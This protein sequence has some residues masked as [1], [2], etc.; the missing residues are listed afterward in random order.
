MISNCFGTLESTGST[1]GNVVTTSESS[2]TQNYGS[3][4]H[5]V[6]LKRVS[7]KKIIYD[8]FKEN[9]K[10]VFRNAIS[11]NLMIA[12]RLQAVIFTNAHYNTHFQ[13]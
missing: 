7:N 10:Y 8:F 2:S 6:L 11:K 12:S 5:G 1:S 9:L 13:F 3:T 4:G